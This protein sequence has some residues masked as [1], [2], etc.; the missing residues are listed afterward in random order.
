MI[1]ITSPPASSAAS[2]T[3]PISPMR[4]PPYT[5]P[6]PARPSAV[7]K[8]RAV[9]AKLGPS[10]ADAPQYTQTRISVDRRALDGDTA[11]RERTDAV[12]AEPLEVFHLVVRFERGQ[13]APRL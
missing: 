11:R 6:I 10:P 9:A 2:A 8:A 7:P 3:A 1:P 13:V 12:P 4:P 5:T